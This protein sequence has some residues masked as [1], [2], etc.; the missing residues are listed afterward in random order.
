MYAYVVCCMVGVMDRSA[1]EAVAGSGAGSDNKHC[2]DRLTHRTGRQAEAELSSD[3][4]RFFF[5]FS[6]VL[7]P[8]E[9]ANLPFSVFSFSYPLL[10]CGR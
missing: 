7:S 4:F 1:V 5:W 8:V 10:R 6:C 9:L 2:T 3:L